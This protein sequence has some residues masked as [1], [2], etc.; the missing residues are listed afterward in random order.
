MC[1]SESFIRSLHAVRQGHLDFNECS[2]EEIVYPTYFT[3]YLSDIFALVQTT[4]KN[5]LSS[6]GLLVE[7]FQF[8]LT[9]DFFD[10]L[11]GTFRVNNLRYLVFKYI[12]YIISFVI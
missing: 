11:L 6:R 10:K 5:G 12:S 9:E 8:V 3:T 7:D 4:L 2:Y 1:N